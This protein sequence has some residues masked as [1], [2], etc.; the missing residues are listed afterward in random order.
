MTGAGPVRLTGLDT[1]FLAL[2]GPATAG[3]LVLLVDV[4]G[5]V[6]LDLVTARIAALVPLHPL[7]RRRV[8]EVPLGLGRPFWADARP[9]LDAHV[10]GAGLP[11]G[12]GPTE[13]A[14]AALAVAAEPLPRERPLWRVDLLRAPSGARSVVALSVHH[15][16]ADGLAIRDLVSELLDPVWEEEPE[17][18]AAPVP[19]EPLSRT[20]RWAGALDLPLAAASALPDVARHLPGAAA[21]AAAAVV[22]APWGLRRPT[23]GDGTAGRVL[24]GAV[25]TQRNLAFGDVP[26]AGARALRASHGATV[27]DVILAATSG[28]LR[29][30]LA[31]GGEPPR[32]PL[33]AAVPATRP[34]SSREGGG[35]TNRFV[36]LRCPLPVHEA[37]RE[38]RLDLVR[39]AMRA[40]R[41]RPGEVALPAE[42]LARFAVP[43]LATPGLRTVGR[44][45]LAGRVTLPVDLMVSNVPMPP[46]ARTLGGHPVRALRPVPLVTEGLGLNVT[47]H[48][49]AERLFVSVASSPRVLA[50]PERLVALLQDEHER[51]AAL[52]G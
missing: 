43:A 16:A 17:L 32:A 48:G 47:V 33:H 38:A 22:T 6:D 9:D 51:L 12:A 52:A 15:A 26:L 4:E 50:D 18:A 31:E 5:E 21:T 7:L 41:E 44:L 29:R 1:A 35:V 40:Q 46:V 2:D 23:R 49:Y 11:E 19:S 25:G 39:S 30:L 45:G 27:N 20:R 37:T 36:V 24:H 3:H 42:A 8:V 34:G 13:L 14:E 10:R 28:A